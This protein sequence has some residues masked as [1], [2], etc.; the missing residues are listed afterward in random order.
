MQEDVK[1]LQ[2]RRILRTFDAFVSTLDASTPTIFSGD[3]NSLPDSKVYNFITS[4]N[5]FNSAYAQYNSDGEPKFTNVNGEAKTDDGKKVPRFVGTLDYIFYRSP[6]YVQSL[7]CH[8]REATLTRFPTAGC[9]QQR[10]WRSCRSKMPARKSLFPVPAL[11][12][13]TSRSCAS[14]TSNLLQLIS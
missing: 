4:S 2:S 3:F 9:D 13:T 8:Y 14:S 10:S 6:R 11:H 5:H 7:S 1:L 12:L